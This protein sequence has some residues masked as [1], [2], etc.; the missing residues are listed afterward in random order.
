MG[1]EEWTNSIDL[2]WTLKC[3]KRCDIQYRRVVYSLMRLRWDSEVV[4]YKNGSRDVLS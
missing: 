4:G 3:H 1:Y 2:L